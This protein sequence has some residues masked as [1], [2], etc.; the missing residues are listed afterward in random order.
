MQKNQTKKPTTIVGVFVVLL[1][2]SCFFFRA[3]CLFGDISPLP[4]FPKIDHF[5]FVSTTFFCEE[6]KISSEFGL[7]VCFVFCYCKN[8]IIKA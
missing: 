1:N 5:C 6:S 2:I 7:C 3:V 4:I 8:K